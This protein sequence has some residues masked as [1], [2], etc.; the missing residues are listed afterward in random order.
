MDDDATARQSWSC[1]LLVP[2]HI[3]PMIGSPDDRER[4]M[5]TERH[6]LKA[7]TTSADDSD[8]AEDSSTGRLLEIMARLRDPLHGC[9]WDVAQ[10]FSSIAPYTIEEAYEV[11]DA[12][13]RGDMADLRDELGDLLLQVVFHAR[14]AEER[15]AFDYG[16]V[17]TAISEKMIRRHPHIFADEQADAPDQV[18]RNWEEIK[19]AER[20]AKAAQA[21]ADAPPSL[22]DGVARALPALQRAEKLQK[23]AARAGF[24]WPSL[25]PVW[26]KLDEEIGELQTEITAGAPPDRL[27]DEMGD[28]LFVL[29]N[30]ARHLK[31]D[32]EAALRR[33]NNKFERRFHRMEEMAAAM[34]R[35]ITAM[36]LDELDALWNRAKEEER[37]RAA[38]PPPDQA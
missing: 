36:S 6:G 12:I 4:K 28:I 34:G 23:R 19:A 9:P 21:G 37:K 7:G 27:E 8:G 1:P 29:A 35:D 13:E 20:R 25:G 30:I 15:G 24:D 17:V 5:S 33:T 16:D 22:L 26:D 11:A 3:L 31:I 14:M 2:P 38:V 32:P 10:D 18:R